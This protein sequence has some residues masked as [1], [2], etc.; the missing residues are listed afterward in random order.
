M[1]MLPFSGPTKVGVNVTL[2]VQLA[3]AA[4]ADPQSF[5]WV[6]SP[7][8]TMLTIFSVEFPVL[9]SVTGNGVLLVPTA[10]SG[11]VRVVGDNSTPEPRPIP[12]RPSVCGLVAASSVIVTVPLSVPEAVGVKVTLMVQLAPGANAFPQ[13]LV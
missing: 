4:R 11:N 1:V 7:A 13:S 5:I 8:E 2:M 6:K 9:V 3:P 10:W 12:V